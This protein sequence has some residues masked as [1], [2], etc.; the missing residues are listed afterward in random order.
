MWQ[1]LLIIIVFL[2][3]AAL[4]MTKKIPTLLALP[5]MAIVICVIAGVPAVGVNEEGAAIGWL[6]TVLEAGVI[7][8]QKNNAWVR[9]SD[10]ANWKRDVELLLEELTIYNDGG[11][12]LP[13]IHLIV[14]KRIVDLSGLQSNEQIYG[15]GGIELAGYPEDEPI[16][17]VGTRRVDT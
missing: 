15:L 7:R 16:I 3:I 5:L 10:A 12:N 1:G 14:G 9:Q 8:L 6:Q 17:V 4:M 2:V 11:V 13:N